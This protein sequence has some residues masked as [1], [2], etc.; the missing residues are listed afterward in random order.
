MKQKHFI[1]SHK[2]ATAPFVLLLIAL[3]GQWDN[4][5]AWLYLATHGSYG[6][7]WVTKSRFFPDKNWEQETHIGYGLAIWGALSLYWISPWLIVSGRSPTPP[8]WYL[9][10]C[11]M[12]F[13]MGV[14]LHFVSDMQKDMSMRHR[15][16]VL[17]TEGFWGIVRNPNYLG[18][19]LI[20][21]GFSLLAMHWIPL[22]ALFLFVVSVW[23]PNM[24]KKDRSLSR[25]PEFAAYKARTKLLIPFIW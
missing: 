19:L 10:M 5:V 20:Y 22:V 16:G 25:Y 13:S 14:L 21:L 3:Y 2:G 8:P 12:L 6:L 9:G 1:D 18:E 7:M 4:V 24:L 17:L 11:V 15:K 23:I